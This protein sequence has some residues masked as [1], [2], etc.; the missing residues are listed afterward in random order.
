MSTPWTVL[1][2]RGEPQTA[3]KRSLVGV[4]RDLE[5]VALG[6]PGATLHTTLQRVEHLTVLTEM[7]WR[8]LAGRGVPVHAYGVGLTGRDDLTC[9]EGLH[10][11][12][13]DPDEQLVREWNVLVVSR[14][15]SAGLAA[16]EVRPAEADPAAYAGGVPLRDG[17]RPFRW[18]TTERD[19]DVR[20]AVDT[21]CH[22]AR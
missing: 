1:A 9:V 17:E 3:P 20:A 4:S 13:L 2:P 21:L 10:L 12:E 16:E 14:D 18:V 15:G 19:A 6:S 7:V 11:H 8:R 5:G 22:L